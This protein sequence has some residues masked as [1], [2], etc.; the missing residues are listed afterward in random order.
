MIREEGSG[1]I[2]PGM[3]YE[4]RALLL[5]S[6]ELIAE[7]AP[8]VIYLSHGDRIGPEQ[9]SSAIAGMRAE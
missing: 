3:F 1:S 7:A 8:R 6:L 9:L 5:A 4:D 2:G